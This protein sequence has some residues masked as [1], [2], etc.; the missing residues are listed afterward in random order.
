MY[1]HST[2]NKISPQIWFKISARVLKGF[3]W[4]VGLFSF[5]WFVSCLGSSG[6]VAFHCFYSKKLAVIL[7][8]ILILGS[9]SSQS[10]LNNIDK[11]QFPKKNREFTSTFCIVLI[12]TAMRISELALT[13][14]TAKMCWCNISAGYF[15]YFWCYQW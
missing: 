3:V 12:H 2:I 1:L 13:K 15:K 7:G 10:L 8:W 9:V 6:F 14:V 4:L 5:C 11:K